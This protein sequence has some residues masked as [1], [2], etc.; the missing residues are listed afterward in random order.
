MEDAVAA[1]LVA[2]TKADE[3]KNLAIRFTGRPPINDL[4]ISKLMS[5]GHCSVKASVQI[6]GAAARM[7]TGGDMQHLR[8]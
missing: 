7:A 6:F 5:T 8:P 3:T 1:V 4:N 2:T